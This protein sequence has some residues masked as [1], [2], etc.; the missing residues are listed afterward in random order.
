M[1][2]VRACSAVY[3]ET[4]V[5]D[6][7]SFSVAPG[8]TLAV[9]G[10]SGC[11]K[12]TL[13]SVI[14]GLKTPAGG[15]SLLN[16]A[17]VSAGDASLILQ[18]YGLFPWFTV[19]ENVEL[20]LR[21]RRIPRSERRA[22]VRA[23]L[24]NV[25]LTGLE[26]RFPAAL[27]GGQQQRVAIARALVLDPAVLLMDEPFSSLDALTRERLQELLLEVLR[28]RQI[29]SIIVTHSIEEAAYLGSSIAVMAG[30]PAQ[31]RMIENPG[32]GAE[33]YRLNPRY[34]ETCRTVRATLERE[35]AR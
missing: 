16:G 22:R 19:M 4:P 25:H 3:G 35:I 24:G 30:R 34:F 5:F 11:G 15:E 32:Q 23:E 20:G 17:R 29:P 1:L 10:P 12:S 9:V 7:L 26:H 6:P 2:E 28:V 33:A 8:E 14:A 31:L 13:L 27:S 21:I 18:Q